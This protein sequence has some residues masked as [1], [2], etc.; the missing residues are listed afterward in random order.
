M[1]KIK[2]ICPGSCASREWYYPHP[3]YD[4]PLIID[5]YKVA[6]AYIEKENRV[7]AELGMDGLFEFVIEK[8]NK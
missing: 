3:L 4:V 8:V 6:E 2:V 7:N 5:N 1:Y